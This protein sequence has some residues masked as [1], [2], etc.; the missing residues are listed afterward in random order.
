MSLDY[1][2][3]ML[4]L[5]TFVQSKKL[6]VSEKKTRG[7]ERRKETSKRSSGGCMLLINGSKHWNDAKKRGPFIVEFVSPSTLLSET[8]VVLQRA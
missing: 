5:P 2:L 7:T 4:R 6:M 1:V 8:P 3:L